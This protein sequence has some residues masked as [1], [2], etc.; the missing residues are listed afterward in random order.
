LLDADKAILP[1]GTEMLL[2][3]LS[4]QGLLT[5]DGEK[6]KSEAVL[7]GEN[8]V[9]NG[10]SMPFADLIQSL[11][12]AGAPSGEAAGS[13][14]GNSTAADLGIPPDLMQRIDKEG[15]TP[16]NHEAAGRK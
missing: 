15:L 9:L 6:I 16:R 3:P 10:K 11:V 2:S 8:I 4:S 5:L 7:D 14:E 1:E 13:T 12:P